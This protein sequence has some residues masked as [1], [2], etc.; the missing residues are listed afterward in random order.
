MLFAWAVEVLVDF[1]P[2][3]FKKVQNHLF[4]LFGYNNHIWT[5]E[6]LCNKHMT[7]LNKDLLLSAKKNYKA[8]KE[9]G[10]G[11]KS[12]C[13]G[14]IVLLLGQFAYVKIMLGMDLN[15]D[16][17][18]A[19]ILILHDEIIQFVYWS[20]MENIHHYSFFLYLI[21]LSSLPSFLHSFF[22]DFPLGHLFIYN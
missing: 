11:R 1:F 15:F 20:L 7:L 13:K 8:S 22:G 3:L 10:S 4:L 9:T 2:P 14:H 6:L 5:R 17:G 18:F 19:K 16:C 21:L 12:F